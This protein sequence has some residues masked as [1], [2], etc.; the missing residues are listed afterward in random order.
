MSLRTT[1]GI[2]RKGKIFNGNEPY[3]CS[4]FSINQKISKVTFSFSNP[5]KLI[6]FYSTDTAEAI[7]GAQ[8]I[9]A[10][11]EQIISVVKNEDASSAREK[12]IKLFSVVKANPSLLAHK[13]EL[14]GLGKAFVLMLNNRITSDDDTI[15]AI[16]GIAYVLVTMSILKN[17]NPNL[18]MNRLLIMEFSREQ[19]NYSIQ[20]A[21]DVMEGRTIS[22]FSPEG[23]MAGTKARDGI[24]KMEIADL[25]TNP[26][27]YQQIDFFKR[28]KDEFDEMIAN[29]FFYNKTL[30]DLITE[31]NRNHEKAYKYFHTKIIINHTIDV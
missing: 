25:Y 30:A 5:E 14:E 13:G 17:A 9:D 3:C 11:A 18:Y 26:A 28:K 12:M 22:F 8:E 29:N 1:T 24:Y 16:A 2:T 21:I 6:E 23:Q 27:L 31:G 4:L 20:S 7:K 15:E 19:F 10:L